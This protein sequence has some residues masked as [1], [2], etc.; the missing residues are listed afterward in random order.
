MPLTSRGYITSAQGPRPGAPAPPW[1][2]LPRCPGAGFTARA[3]GEREPVGNRS[4]RARMQL[5]TPKLQDCLRTKIV[6]LQASLVM[7]NVF[8]WLGDQETLGA[9]ELLVM[10]S[11]RFG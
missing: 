6:T 2:R 10:A 5:P 1:A 7:C 9:W 8:M 11:D 4:H 3:H